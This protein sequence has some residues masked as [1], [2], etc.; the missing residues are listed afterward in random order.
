MGTLEQ[1]VT[2]EGGQYKNKQTGE[3]VK[4]VCWRKDGDHPSVVRYP[5]ERRDFKGLLIV[6]PKE[7]H[8]LVYGDWIAETEAGDIYIV[9]ADKFGSIY[10]EVKQEAAAA[11]PSA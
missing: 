3:V 7:K 4:A 2:V 1:T 9:P 11:A 10:E 5:I 6:S 8:A